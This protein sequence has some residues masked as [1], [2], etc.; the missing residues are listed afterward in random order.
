MVIHASIV[1][2]CSENNVRVTGLQ[3]IWKF[4]APGCIELLFKGSMQEHRRELASP[5]SAPVILQQTIISDI[6]IKYL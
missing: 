4:L 6:R 5:K 1:K 2:G 3:M